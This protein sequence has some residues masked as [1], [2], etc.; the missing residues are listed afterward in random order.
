[1]T[2]ALSDDPLTGPEPPIE[3]PDCA[4]EHGTPGEKKRGVIKVERGGT[5]EDGA[6]DPCVCVCVAVPEVPRE[7]LGSAAA[8]SGWSAQAGLPAAV[9]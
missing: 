2:L 8:G 7:G 9:G 3:S 1:M 4:H 6:G 5:T